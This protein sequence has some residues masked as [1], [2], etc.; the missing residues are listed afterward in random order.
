MFINSVCGI[1]STGRIVSDLADSFIKNGHEV[2]IAYGRDDAPEK[3]QSISYRI[4][5]DYSVII[6]GIEARLFDN[7]GFNAVSSTKK[8]I[9]W[10]NTYDPDLLWL[11]NLH[12]YYIN[13]ELLFEWIKSRPNMTVKWT[14]HDCWAFTGHCTHFQVV[15][16]DRW[17]NGG[18]CSCPQY[19]EYPTSIFVDRSYKNY[20]NKKRIFCGV[21]NLTIYT[22]SVWLKKLVEDSFLKSYPVYVYPNPINK[23]VFKQTPSS[24]KE[25][26][27]LI[28]KKMILG[29][30]SV[31]NERKG[32]NDCIE[33]AK[34]LDSSY[35]LVLVGLARKELK[36]VPSN[37]ICI[38]STNDAYYL[39]KIYTAADLFLNLSV[40][41]TFSMTTAE[42]ISCG[43]F[44]IVYKGTA[45]EELI[46]PKTGIAI[47]HDM[48]D[49][50]RTV[51]GLF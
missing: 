45:C 2:R 38:P 28:Y 14:L 17:K 23:N 36:D 5:S 16:C 32:L 37:L 40:E 42:A 43:T 47:S 13:C 11:H 27:G 31:W 46:D 3:Y 33:L 10:A 39:A 9:E 50:I 41:E 18:C 21:N 4:S 35:C 8:L 22:P 29:V 51:K 30:S 24:I 1:K 49:L 44:A 26:L 20:L 25:D 19:K 48:D 7:E 34:N 6:N 12:G 15:G